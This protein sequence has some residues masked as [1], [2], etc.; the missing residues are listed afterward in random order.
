MTTFHKSQICPFAKKCKFFKKRNCYKIHSC[1]FY[2]NCTN[3][4][5]LFDHVFVKRK[6]TAIESTRTI[7]IKGLNEDMEFLNAP[8]KFKYFT[9]LSADAP[10]FIPKFNTQ[11]HTNDNF[12]QDYKNFNE[13]FVENDYD[14]YDD[15]Y[16]DQY[17]DQYDYYDE[18]YD[19]EYDDEYDDDYDDNSHILYDGTYFVYRTEQF[20]SYDAANNAKRLEE[21]EFEEISTMIKSSIN[22]ST[23]EC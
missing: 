17:Y 6:I 13:E 9:T 20:L 8:K 1:H 19:D 2:P 3:T 10:L 22:L 12:E 14:K 7:P 18:Y 4:S 16:Y 21:Q 15:Q 23:L 5:C 11:I